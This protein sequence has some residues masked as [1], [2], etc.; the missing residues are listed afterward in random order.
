MTVS[1][2]ALQNIRCIAWAE[3]ALDPDLSVIYGPN[4]S[5][6]TTLLE[7]LFL[8]GRGRSFR[9]ARAYKVIR[10]GEAA[11]AVAAD[12][13]GEQPHRIRIDLTVGEPTSA[14]L[15]ERRTA[16]LADLATAL[17]VQLIDPSVHRLIEDSALWRRRFLDWG[18]FHVEPGFVARMARYG[19]IL[20]QRNELLKQSS[21]ATADWDA[22]FVE[23]GE[24]I[25]L[26]RRRAFDVMKPALE[27][28]LADVLCEPVTLEL[29]PGWSVEQ[30]L[31]EALRSA[32]RRD[33][34]MRTSTVGPHRAD[35][36]IRHAGRPA[37][38]S[39]SRGQ[40]KLVAAA[41]IVGQLEWLQTE[42]ALRPTL[43]IDDPAAEL[44]EGH[45][46]RLL[47]RIRA[48]DAQLV[49]TTLQPETTLFGPVRRVFHVE[50]GGVRRV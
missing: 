23:L 19:R 13:E 7:S 16:A 9:A 34:A 32:H 18:V 26:A 8:A 47:G 43:L 1:R 37:R 20:R 31:A 11:A 5:G 12:T 22:E 45:L 42:R 46:G 30:G 35:L 40:Q 14:T 39:L 17:P 15:D 36:V 6:K 2:L 29:R 49:V 33:Q 44:D 21:H 41:L 24:A 50:H 10:D 27:R 38:E 4:G 3:L 28:C 25:A 48:L